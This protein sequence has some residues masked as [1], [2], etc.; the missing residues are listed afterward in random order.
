MLH[1]SV[2]CKDGINSTLWSMVTEYTAYIYN[3]MPDSI[4]ISPA[5]IFSGT[6]FPQ[7]KLRDIHPW[8]C[9]SYVLDPTLQQGKKLPK[10]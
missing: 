9:P 4:G 10:W 6:Q 2:H 1:V 7:Q 5:D 3:N 8:G